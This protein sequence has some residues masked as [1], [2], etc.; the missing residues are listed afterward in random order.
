MPSLNV[1]NTGG[2]IWERIV[3][4]K[5]PVVEPRDSADFPTAAQ[6]FRDKLNDPSASGAVFLAVCRCSQKAL[7]A[8]R[9]LP[10]LVVISHSTDVRLQR[11]GCTSWTVCM[12]AMLA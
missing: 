12:T 3:K 10:A 5:L 1:G 11:S 4:H 9:W 2:S 7:H 6:D 8:V